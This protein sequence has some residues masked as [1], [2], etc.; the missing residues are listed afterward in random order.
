ME[1]GMKKI[2]LVMMIAALALAACSDDG[3]KVCTDANCL[4]S[5][6]AG[7]KS[8]ATVQ[9]SGTIEG[10]FT[11]PAGVTLEGTGGTAILKSAGTGPVISVTADGEGTTIR[12][13]S[14][15]G[16]STGGIYAEGNGALTLAQ[17]SISVTGGFCIKVSEIDTLTASNL[18]LSGNVT[19]EVQGTRAWRW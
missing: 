19:E 13:L 11:V 3:G 1:A 6:L 4:T 2:F 7:A 17:L 10:N 5:A 15:E 16:G 12:N 8:G 18:S 14:V 9:V